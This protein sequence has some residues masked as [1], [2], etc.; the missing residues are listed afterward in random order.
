MGMGLIGKKCGMT[1]VFKEDGTSIPVTVIEVSPNK[2][3]QIKTVDTDTYSAIQV[4]T[5][6]QPISHV[7]KPIAGHYAKSDVSAGIGLWEFRLDESLLN[8]DN[9]KLGNSLTVDV[10][11]EGQLVDVR[12]FSRGKGFA[13]T[14]K[15]WNFSSQPMSH[16]NSLA[17]RALGSI[18]QNQNPR[19][20]FKNKKMPGR[21]GNSKCT[22]QNQK[23]VKIDAERNL[24]LI[25]GVVSGAPGSIV[26]ILPSCKK[27]NKVIGEK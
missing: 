26:M 22:I 3:T 25:K 15:R 18:G 23:I 27:N 7:N 12:S 6:E 11:T 4:T 2:I 10:F 13:G 8:D 5:G 24:L 19:K 21:M 1:R 9:L 20:V 16:G 17:H 14:I